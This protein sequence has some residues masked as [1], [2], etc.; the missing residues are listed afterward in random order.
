M[1]ETTIEKN[2]TDRIPEIDQNIVSL[3]I[4]INDPKAVQILATVPPTQIESYIEKAIII[5]DMVL[6]HASIST[7]KD[8]VE[9]FFS[10][11][12]QDIDR[13]REQLNQV[14][15]TIMTPAKKGAMTEE[16][17]Y[18][19][20]EE[21]FLDDS[22]EN[23]SGKGKYSDILATINPE[24][25]PVLI[26]SK[27]YKNSVPT[28]QV[29]KFWRDMEFRDARYGIF[30]SMR[31]KIAKI[32]GCITLKR[33]QNRT[34]IFVVNNDL[35]Y[36]G[37]IFAFY[38]IKKLVEIESLKKQDLSITDMDTSLSKINGLLSEIRQ[39][40]ESVT[41]ISTI[42]EALKT[43][44][45]KDLDEIVKIARSYDLKFKEQIQSAMEELDKM[46]T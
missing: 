39:T 42:A 13:I 44:N 19:S 21:H 30:V 22:F 17:I 34:A 3:N 6:N 4:T 16:A 40:S 28:H 7:S 29:D 24:S 46:T 43:K 32:S 25:I 2:E 12:R 45:V 27:D 15:P 41:Q 26:E 18:T 14:V 1:S 23:V 35:G 8:T 37:H 38:V 5:S 31:S 10:P 20:Y 36:T 33:N 9:N 11:L